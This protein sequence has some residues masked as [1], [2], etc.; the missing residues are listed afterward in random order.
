[1]SAVKNPHQYSVKKI[2]KRDCSQGRASI[3]AEPLFTL[4]DE[5]EDGEGTQSLTLN[6]PTDATEV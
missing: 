1:M 6:S 4:T 5:D 3:G 2:E